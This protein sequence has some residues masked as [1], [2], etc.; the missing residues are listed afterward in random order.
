MRE[1]IGNVDSLDDD[2]SATQEEQEDHEGS[3][4]ERHRQ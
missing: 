1:E 4:V 2:D 3:G